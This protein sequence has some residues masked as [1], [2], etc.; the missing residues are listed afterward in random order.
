[1]SQAG[2]D[3]DELVWNMT[4]KAMKVLNVGFPV[5]EFRAAHAAFMFG[6]QYLEDRHIGPSEVMLSYKSLYGQKEEKAST[7]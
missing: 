6:M 7:I 1:M 2:L 3:L 5:T 4:L